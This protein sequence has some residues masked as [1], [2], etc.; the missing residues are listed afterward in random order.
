MEG[1]QVSLLQQSDDGDLC[2]NSRKIYS[3]EYRNL[4]QMLMIEFHTT[5]LLGSQ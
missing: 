1:V 2:D 5:I 3:K 4:V